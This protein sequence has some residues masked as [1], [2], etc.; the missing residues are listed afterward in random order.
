MEYEF[1]SKLGRLYSYFNSEKLGWGKSSRK[2]REKPFGSYE[3]FIKALYPAAQGCEETEKVFFTSK[4]VEQC[5]KTRDISDKT[6]LFSISTIESNLSDW[7]GKGKYSIPP[8]ELYRESNRKKHA[9]YIENH[10]VGRVVNWMKDDWKREPQVCLRVILKGIRSVMDEDN[11]VENCIFFHAGTRNTTSLIVAEMLFDYV[12]YL[13]GNPIPS[14]VDE[15]MCVKFQKDMKEVCN[16]SLIGAAESMNQLEARILS[17]A[18]NGNCVVQ[19]RIAADYYNNIQKGGINFIEKAMCLITKMIG[20]NEELEKENAEDGREDG[21]RDSKGIRKIHQYPMPHYLRACIR[22]D[23]VFLRKKS[24]VPML[25]SEYRS[26]ESYYQWIVD[27]LVAASSYGIGGAFE[28]LGDLIDDD[29]CPEKIRDSIGDSLSE[30]REVEGD[31][32][33]LRRKRHMY[34]FGMHC[35]NS[36]CGY[37]LA[38]IEERIVVRRNQYLEE[39]VDALLVACKAGNFNACVKLTVLIIESNLYQNKRDELISAWEIAIQVM[40]SLGRAEEYASAIWNMVLNWEQRMECMANLSDLVKSIKGSQHVGYV[41][42]D[43]MAK[44]DDFCKRRCVIQD[45]FAIKNTISMF[46]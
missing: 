36:N 2:R 1:G 34:R 22:L 42:M 37:K 26:K 33:T 25:E 12:C 44:E 15:K 35:G 23:Y 32:V 21:R 19:Y 45:L 8:K 16:Q 29:E 39:I 40:D 17:L 41:M 38:E 43:I 4:D 14:Y 3:Q 31:S 27:D 24:I 7:I 10:F 6:R 28:L 13:I 5:I 18:Y 11:L 20:K 46:D 30:N 9:S